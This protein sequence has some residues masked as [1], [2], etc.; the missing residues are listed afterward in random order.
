M[1]FMKMHEEHLRQLTG[2]SFPVIFRLE[3]VLTAILSDKGAGAPFKYQVRAMLVATLIKLRSGNAYRTMAIYLGIPYVTLNRYV[4]RVC[5][6]L[7]DRPLD[8]SQSRHYLIVDGTCL[9]IRSSD[10]ADYSGYKLHKN[11]KVQVIVDDSGRII[12]VSDSYNG[13]VHD[14]T[15]WNKEYERLTKILNKPVLADKAYAGAKGENAILS[16][17]I[18]RNEVAYKTDKEACKASNREL[19]KK[20]VKVEHVF[21]Q[22]KAYRIL[23]DIFSHS[24]DVF[25]IFFKA[26]ALIYNM[27]L[28]YKKVKSG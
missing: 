20:R 6:I 9:R 7:A 3:Q 19:S 11:R 13:A 15:I 2:C 4:R 10:K 5:A 26:V 12:D 21:A 24:P 28:E 17:P 16:R 22:L 27:T 18:K 23:R 1:N 8:T 14:K 25:G